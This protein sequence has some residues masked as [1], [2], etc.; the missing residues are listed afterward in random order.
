[1]RSCSREKQATANHAFLKLTFESANGEKASY[2]HDF[3]VRSFSGKSKFVEEMF[4]F[5]FKMNT[6]LFYVFLLFVL[7][8]KCILCRYGNFPYE[9]YLRLEEDEQ[10]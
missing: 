5:C 6:L 8:M 10:L 1:M 7:T 3:V 2:L 9:K 4:F